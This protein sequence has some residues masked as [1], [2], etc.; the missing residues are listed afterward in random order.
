MANKYLDNTGLSTLWNIIKNALNLK[1]NTNGDAY[2]ASSIPFGQVDSSS[3]ATVFT[4]TVDGITELRDGVCMWLKNG[5]VTSASGFTININGLGAKPVYSNLAEAS[6]STTIFNVAYTML[7]VY[8]ESRVTGGCWDIVY[9]Y[10][11]NTNTIG[12]QVRHNSGTGKASAKTYRYRLLFTGDD[13]TL[14]PANTSSSTNATSARAVNQTPINP[15]G[16]IYYYGSTSAVNADS[17]FSAASLWQQYAISLGYSFNQTGE[18]LTLSYPKA[19]YIKATPTSDGKAIIDA[20][21]PYVQTLPNAEDGKIYIY[22]G[23]AYSATN[24]E[25]DLHHPVYYFYN[26]KIQLWTGIKAEENQNAFS[27]IK[28]DST[29]VSADSKTDTLELTAGNN[30]TLTPDTTNDKVT[31]AATD[32]T[33]SAG[34]GLSLSGTTFSNSGVTGIKGNDENS[35]RTGQVNLTPLNIGAV[36]KSDELQTTNPFAP[37]SLK[38]MYISKIDNGFYAADKRWVIDGLTAWEASVIFNGNYESKISITKETSK[39]F[40]IDFE[41]SEIDVSPYNNVNC[42]AGYPYGYILLSFYNASVPE[43][44]S[45]RIYCNYEPHGIGWHDISF[46]PASDNTTN[47]CVYRGRQSCYA[48][49]KLEITINAGANTNAELTQME[50]HLDRPDSQRTPFLSKYTPETLYYNLTAPKFIGDVAASNVNATTK[51]TTPIVETGNT[52]PSYFQTERLR[53]EGN[54]STYY[55]AIDFGKSGHNQVDFYEYGG[56]FNFHKH[57]GATIDAGDTLLGTI[58]NKGWDGKVNNHTVNADVP[59]NAVFTDTTYS[60]AT[61]T[62]SGLMS[63]T[64]KAHLDAVYDDYSTAL[65]ALL[66]GGE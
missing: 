2:R 49:S 23:Q 28:I 26:G 16:S 4:A 40:T 57:T 19:V 15:F 51:V 18:A 55:H 32:T 11:S 56:V 14:V 34:T 38:G 59:A 3:T 21:T 27:N 63:A 58:N 62:T 61:T 35:Y 48:I 1:L 43:S 53:G 7:F 42:M 41:N 9:G 20:D 29:I 46:I 30:I 50:I 36:A 60:E 17:S 25:L 65:T 12:Y 6:R 5:V 47:A 64:D 39:T 54:A 44:V 8:N 24:V 31:I 10:D 45:G 13:D 37:N 66:G 52:T 22:L 33:Y